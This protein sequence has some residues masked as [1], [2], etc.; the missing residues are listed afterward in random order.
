M[1]WWWSDDDGDGF[2]GEQQR[3]VTVRKQE[4]VLY[5]WDNALGKREL[6]WSCGKKK[7][8]KSDLMQVSTRVDDLHTWQDS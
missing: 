5:T 6:I 2:S 8:M 4:A 7:D 3:V 1:K